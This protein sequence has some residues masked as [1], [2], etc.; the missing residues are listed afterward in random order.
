MYRKLYPKLNFAARTRT[1]RECQDLSTPPCCSPSPLLGKI[2]SL[3]CSCSSVPWICTTGGRPRG[4]VF[5]RTHTVYLILAASSA[6]V[7]SRGGLLS[8]NSPSDQRGKEAILR[9]PSLSRGRLY[10][11][12]YAFHVVYSR[13]RA[14]SRSRGNFCLGSIM[15]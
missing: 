3:A 2:P 14:L 7:Q 1:G 12:A 5:N 4:A 10:E 13:R 8:A 15:M 11:G 6:H 9:E